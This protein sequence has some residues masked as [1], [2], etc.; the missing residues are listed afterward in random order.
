VDKLKKKKRRK[1]H[2]SSLIDFIENFIIYQQ[3]TDH[4]RLKKE[5]NKKLKQASL[6]RVSLARRVRIQ[7]GNNIGVIQVVVSR[8]VRVVVK[9]CRVA[10]RVWMVV[11]SSGRVATA[12]RG[13]YRC[14][15]R[16]HR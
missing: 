5:E 11:A 13:Q 2:N 10:S 16:V 6:Q 7:I 8:V 15:S 9:R 4:F 3:R 1:S 14:R 12:Q